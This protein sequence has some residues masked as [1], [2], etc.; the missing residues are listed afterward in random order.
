M[1]R[2]ECMECME[3]MEF[4]K[5][6]RHVEG[7]ALREGYCVSTLVSLKDTLFLLRLLKMNSM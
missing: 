2:I 4:D 5:F 7:P 6:P 3:C 1:E